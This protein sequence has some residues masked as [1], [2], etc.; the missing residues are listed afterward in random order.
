MSAA[1]STNILQ[2]L[3]CLITK[4]EGGVSM[5][6]DLWFTD[7]DHK[8]LENILSSNKIS[9]MKGPVYLKQKKTYR[10]V[11]KVT[12]SSAE[13]SNLMKSALQETDAWVCLKCQFRHPAKKAILHHIHFF[14]FK[15]LHECN[16]C[17]YTT[18][19]KGALQTH[20]KNSHKE[21]V[22]VK[23]NIKT[24]EESHVYAC[25]IC[26]FKSAS[27]GDLWVHQK[28]SHKKLHPLTR[29]LHTESVYLNLRDNIHPKSFPKVLQYPNGQIGQM[30]PSPKVIRYPPKRTLLLQ[31]TPAGKFNR[32]TKIN[33]NLDAAKIKNSELR[34][35]EPK[36]MECVTAGTNGLFRCTR[37]EYGSGNRENIL[38]HV[39]CFH[40]PD[41]FVG[42]QCSQCDIVERCRF[43]LMTH[44]LDVH[45]SKVQRRDFSGAGAAPGPSVGTT[46]APAPATSTLTT[47]T[48]LQ[49][50]QPKVYVYRCT[51]CKDVF[52]HRPGLHKHLQEVHS[53]KSVEKKKYNC[54]S[55]T[56]FSFSQ[57]DI[58]AHLTSHLKSV[59][60]KSDNIQKVSTSILR[61][62]VQVAVPS[63]G[64]KCSLCSAQFATE[65]LLK[66]H[67]QRDE[68]FKYRCSSCDSL[69]RN[70]AIFEEHSK[71]CTAVKNKTAASDGAEGD[72]SLSLT[73]QV[74]SLLDILGHV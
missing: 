32:V 51:Y 34:S 63:A 40:P 20:K 9:S 18:E 70:I 43:S 19:F 17:E 57:E 74:D 5:E 47:P 60:P 14:H 38:N 61:P 42:Y 22:K 11:T 1:D 3:N 49:P 72:N 27:K 65:A 31:P 50:M 59:K 6:P 36:L 26:D 16:D 64:P 71:N 8:D 25:N 44:F 23:C 15:Q 58:T 48:H 46:S 66:D 62:P 52:H 37:C 12:F 2:D 4:F 33:G 69:F 35:W 28:S 7:T 73:E 55:C 45:G 13:E 67:L 53:V 39:E 10:K 30:P 29:P 54:N 41:H 24:N 68:G 56:Y 21:K